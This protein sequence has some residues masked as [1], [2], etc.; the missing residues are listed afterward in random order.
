MGSSMKV[1]KNLVAVAVITFCLASCSQRTTC[2][3]YGAST[4]QID[5]NQD[6]INVQS[7]VENVEWM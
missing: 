5:N 7:T 1:F 6:E 2:A 4:Y 3:A